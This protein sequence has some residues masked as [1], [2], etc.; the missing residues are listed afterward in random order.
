[1]FLFCSYESSV[2]ASEGDVSHLRLRRGMSEEVRPTHNC[3]G[4]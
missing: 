4:E 2:T 3:N 1:M